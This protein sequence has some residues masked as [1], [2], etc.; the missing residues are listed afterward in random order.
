MSGQIQPLDATRTTTVISDGAACTFASAGQSLPL[1]SLKAFQEVFIYR[2]EI[3]KEK[4]PKELWNPPHRSSDFIYLE[5]S[6]NYQSLQLAYMWSVEAPFLPCSTS[7]T[8]AGIHTC[9]IH[10]AACQ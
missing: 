5:T 4:H 7:P 8:R 6:L 1:R 10:S 2:Q 3:M 9:A